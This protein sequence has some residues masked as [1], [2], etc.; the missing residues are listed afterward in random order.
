MGIMKNELRKVSESTGDA[1]SK[2]I[3]ERI[4]DAMERLGV[5][6]TEEIEALTRRIELLEKKLQ[7]K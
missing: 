3:D 7:A 6:R 1:F 5:A 2:M 4:S